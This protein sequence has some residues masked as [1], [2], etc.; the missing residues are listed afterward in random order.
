MKAGYG[1]AVSVSAALLFGSPLV[2]YGVS[3]LVVTINNEQLSCAATTCDLTGQHAGVE[4]LNNSGTAKVKGTEGD[5]DTL[6]LE[7]V[8]IKALQATE[9]VMTFY[10]TFA[11]PPTA[12]QANNKKVKFDRT[13]DGNMKRGASAAKNDKFTINAWV[14]DLEDSNA[15]FTIE[16]TQYKLVTCPWATCP[17]SYGNFSL[18]TYTEFTTGFTAGRIMKVEIKFDA[19]YVN[20]TLNISLVELKGATP[21][22][23]VDGSMIGVYDSFSEE[24]IKIEHEKNLD[25]DE[26]K[27][28][29]KSKKDRPKK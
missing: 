6:R 13:A 5:V 4:F 25:S 26:D 24:Q 8:T 1:L 18:A 10:A 3:D 11:Q 7:S 2:S 12:D 17:A 16:P 27:D 19:K 29:G 14:D 15:E 28:K 22:G 20:D 9:H 23:G 21:A